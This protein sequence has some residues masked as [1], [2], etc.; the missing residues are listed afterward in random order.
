MKGDSYR[1]NSRI[2]LMEFLPALLLDVS[3]GYC[4]RALVSEAGK[5]RT[6]MG[7]HSISVMVTVYGMP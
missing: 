3:T 7:K 6:Q 2:F 4:Q 5:I 1:L